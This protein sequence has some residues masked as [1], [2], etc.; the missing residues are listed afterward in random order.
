MEVP[1]SAIS[2]FTGRA[3]GGRKLIAVA[4]IDMVG[5]SRL[6][7]L[8]DANTIARLQTLRRV[9]IDPAVDEHGGMLVQTAG[10]SL[11]IVFDSI[12]GAVRCAVK[13]QLLVPDH[14]GNAPTERRIRFRIGINIGD[15]IAAGTDLHGDGVNVA[16]RL[17]TECPEGGVCVSQ[18]VRDH[19][20]DRL[21]L[22]FEELGSLTLK[23]ISR[24]VRAFVI[25]GREIGQLTDPATADKP[26]SAM[27]GTGPAVPAAPASSPGSNRVRFPEF[28]GQPAIAVLPFRSYTPDDEPFTDGL[29]DELINALSSWRNFP[30]IARNSVFAYRGRDI[31]VRVI[32]RD[33]G[34][35]YII[36][37][38]VRRD[39]AQARVTLELVD[40]ETAGNLLSEHYDHTSTDPFAMQ[41]EI[42]RAIAGILWPEMLK[43]ERDRAVRR[44][45][46]DSNVYDLFERGMWYRYRNTSEDLERAASLFR[47]A[48]KIDPHYARATAALSLCY[49]FA[50]QSH[51]TQDVSAARAESLALARQ[52]VADD[53]R[54]PHAH[55]ALG[56]ACMNVRRLPEAIQELRE[57]VRL[58]PS[59]AFAHANLGQVFNYL[60]RPEEGLPQVELAL[61]LNPHDPRRFMW[62]PYVAT[63]HYLSRRYKACLEASEQA[64]LANPD[65]PHAVRYMVA[66]LGQL[67]RVAEARPLLAL[68]RRYDRDMAGLE[69]LTRNFFQGDAAEHLLEGFRRAG[70]T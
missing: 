25:R 52:A 18:A 70:F 65:Y 31:D 60:N 50:A 46:T 66:A 27:P 12:D 14:D 3:A 16:V 44:S 8:D 57:A 41:D 54:D 53:P 15:V 10:D 61:R 40:A 45:A 13:V 64:L 49:N 62:L 51:W 67:G 33:L 4:H 59:H 55:F 56:V 1:P 17:Q 9:L 32:G 42:V 30:V 69:A 11:L 24:P 34:A 26:G 43:L 23:N 39:G 48:L 7:G 37:G 68:L 21:N 5:Y 29:T 22:A 19:V 58:N 20:H 35:R 63:S 36:G 47:E 6:I 2:R 28:G 38:S